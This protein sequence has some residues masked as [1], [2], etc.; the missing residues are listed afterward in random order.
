M[1]S[2]STQCAHE[3][4]GTGRQV[5]HND[6]GSEEG[7][8]HRVEVAVP[9]Q[10]EVSIGVVPVGVLLLVALREHEETSSEPPVLAHDR[11]RHVTWHV[12]VRVG[13]QRRLGGPHHLRLCDSK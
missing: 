10:R 7:E 11:A 8:E 13:R 6:E 1:S 12:V 5:R 9:P 3:R 4:P 2:T